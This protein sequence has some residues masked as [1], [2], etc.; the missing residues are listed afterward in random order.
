MN[1]KLSTQA[2]SEAA[3]DSLTGG[4][5]AGEIS[6]THA[7]QMRAAAEMNV[8]APT[9]DAFYIEAKKD[10]DYTI[11]VLPAGPE[12]VVLVLSNALRDNRYNED[13][14]EPLQYPVL[15]VRERAAEHFGRSDNDKTAPW[16]TLGVYRHVEL[17]G[18]SRLEY[19]PK[20]LRLIRDTGDTAT[21]V[22]RTTGPL[23]VYTNAKD[24][25]ITESSFKGC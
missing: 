6:L 20:G 7:V 1:E 12:R 2:R 5:P 13:D 16:K 14:D 4:N 19:V 10:S 21:V 17:L 25:Q 3:L 24:A 18:A 8:N 23:R 22:L 9:M 11:E 15:V